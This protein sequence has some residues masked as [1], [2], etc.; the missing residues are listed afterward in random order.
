MPVEESIEAEKPE[1]T[2]TRPAYAGPPA[3]RKGGFAVLRVLRHPEF[4]IF[5]GGQA[6]SLV[7]TWM[8][9]FA[10]GWVVAG[11]TS[12]ALALGL[13]S[14]AMSVPTLLLMPMGGVTADRVERRKILI[15]TQW[16]MGILAAIT[17]VLVATHHLQLWHLYV[18]AL[19]LGVATA[20][21][22][23]AYQAFYPQLIERE[24]LGQAIA[25]NQATFNGS[26]IIGPALAAMVVTWWGTSA[27]F[28]ANAASFLAVIFSLSFIRSRPP[29]VGR[30][31]GGAMQMM[32]EGVAYVRE[33]PILQAL[34]GVT[35]LTTF[36]V[37]PNLAVLMPFYALHVLHVGS[38]SLGTL[39]AVSG[40]GSFLGA[41]SLLNVPR[42]RRGVSITLA[43]VTITLTLTLLAWSHSL[44]LSTGVVFFQSMAISFSVGLASIMV[45]ETVPDA[46]R[47]R[48][49]SLYSLMFTGI[50]PF[51]T[52]AITGL[53]DS[54]GMRRELQLSAILYGIGMSILMVLLSRHQANATA[55]A[56]AA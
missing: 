19:L 31:G 24:E 29:A 39:M 34:L 48:V 35:G 52:L 53:A 46:L 42:E 32:K 55:A 6:V 45:Q 23:P 21:D 5:W 50:M 25:L 51:A 47:G 4:A 17:G 28:F 26:R 43:G 18:V 30:G 12:S 20:Y 44:W 10:Q 15:Y 36:F 38:A 9:N 1:P 11:M 49:M 7:G 41:V 33:R 8:Q 13:V 40:A 2:A 56:A 27:A 37:F 3:D 22:L 54:I 16:A 14:F